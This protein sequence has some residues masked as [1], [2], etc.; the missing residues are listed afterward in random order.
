MN[1]KN[2]FHDGFYA[3]IYIIDVLMCRCVY[4]SLSGECIVVETPL[5]YE[6]C[7]SAA[8]R[9]TLLDK[10][11]GTRIFGGGYSQITCMNPKSVP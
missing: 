1:M 7:V 8:R 10:I 4:V 6:H 5:Y 3:Y 2:K 11:R 9:E